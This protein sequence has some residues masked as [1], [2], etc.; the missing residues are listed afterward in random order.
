M[1]FSGGKH[2]LRYGHIS[3][4][5]IPYV[6]CEIRNHPSAELRQTGSSADKHIKL[7]Y[8][9]LIP[10]VK[11]HLVADCRLIPAEFHI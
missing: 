7:F 9:F 1:G 3:G 8:A 11:R 6:F 4:V 10:A 2:S 5:D